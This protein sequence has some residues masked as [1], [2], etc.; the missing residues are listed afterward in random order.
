MATTQ[1]FAHIDSMRAIAALLVVWLHTSEE[2]IK[3]ATPSVQD[4]LYSIAYLP[5]FGRIGVVLF[6]AISGFVI[7]S[8]LRGER[9]DACRTFLVKRLFRLFPLY[10]LSIPLG[11]L[12]SWTIWGKDLSATAIAWNLSMV[13]EAAGY[14]SAQGLYWTLQTELVFYGLCV[15]LFAVGLLRS[16]LFLGALVL[17]L[18]AICLLPIL[19]PFLGLPVTW[20]ASPTMAMLSLHLGVMFW[21]ALFRLWY[22]GKPMHPLARLS[23]FGFVGCWVT[24]GLAGVL[25]HLLIAANIDLVRFGVPYASGVLL[26]AVLATVVRI[27]AGWLVWLGTVSY[28]IYL[29]HPVVMYAVSWAIQVQAVGWLLGWPIGA[30]MLVA[31]MGTIALSALTYRFVEVPAMNLGES[32][33]RRWRSAPAAVAVDPI[34]SP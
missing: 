32:L 4:Y 11:V 9:L 27:R 16:A 3:L 6:F 17:A 2:F 15:L 30:Y 26:F 12:T 13:Q 7:P 34:R 31:V 28:S 25:Y 5:D 10:W 8:S 23:V 20:R 21:G 14:P 18:T 1:R 29:F 33:A 22:D 24:L 19:L